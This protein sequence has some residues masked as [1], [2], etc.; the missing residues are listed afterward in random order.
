MRVELA[1]IFMSLIFPSL[2]ENLAEHSLVFMVHTT[3]VTEKLETSTQLLNT[4]NIYIHATAGTL[5]G[6]LWGRQIMMQIYNVFKSYGLEGCLDSNSFTGLQPCVC[7][8]K[9]E[10][11]LQLLLNRCT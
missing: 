9:T 11:L 6:L 8:I 3:F 7:A 10:R 2:K 1:K 4:D 5:S